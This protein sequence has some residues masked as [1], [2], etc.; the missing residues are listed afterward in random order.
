MKVLQL[1][2]PVKSLVAVNGGTIVT[3]AKTVL[4]TAPDGKR[5]QTIPVEK[6]RQIVT[7]SNTDEQHAYVFNDQILESFDL[8]S[9]SVGRY[10]LPFDADVKVKGLKLGSGLVHMIADGKIRLFAFAPVTGGSK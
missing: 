9:Q 6:S 1:K 8:A 10:H 3:T 5:L 4:I 7:A 2:Q